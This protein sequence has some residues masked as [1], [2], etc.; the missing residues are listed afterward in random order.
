MEE[1][2]FHD[3]NSCPLKIRESFDDGKKVENSILPGFSA[4]ITKAIAPCLATSKQV[5]AS[6]SLGI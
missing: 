3:V 2:F 1:N 5:M 4:P 6:I